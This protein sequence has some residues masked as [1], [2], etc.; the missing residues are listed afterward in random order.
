MLDHHAG[1]T[2]AT[3]APRSEELPDFGRPD[4]AALRGR[5]DHPV[6]SDVVAVLQRRAERGPE[7]VAY[8]DD[9]PAGLTSGD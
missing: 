7:A 3:P 2:P 8:Y 5:T 9:A 4:L 1:G 6:L